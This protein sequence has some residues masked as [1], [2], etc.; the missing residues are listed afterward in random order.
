MEKT[1]LTRKQLYDLMW[2]EPRTAIAKRFHITDAELKK[3]CESMNIPL[4]PNGYWQK[5]QFK[6]PVDIKKLPVDY[7]GSD[8]VVFG[9]TARNYQLNDSP[10]GIQNRLVRELE[11]DPDLPLMVPDRLTKPDILITSTQNYLD[12]VRRYDWSK[13]D[14][15]PSRSNTL[16]IEVSKELLPRA[17]RIMNAIISLLKARKHSMIVK[18]DRTLA[19]IYGE[20]ILIRLRERYKRVASKEKYRDWENEPTRKLVLI[21]GDNWRSIEVNDGIEGLEMKLAVILAKLEIWA[22]KEIADRIERERRHKIYEEERRLES[23]LKARKEKELT[24]FKKIFWAATRYNQAN[25]L[26]DYI[27]NVETT[28]KESGSLTE[29]KQE[30]IDW[31][32]DKIDWYDPLIG[33]EDQLLDGFNKNSLMIEFLSQQGERSQHSSGQ[34]GHYSTW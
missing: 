10:S 25:F 26:R 9:G 11:N 12:A 13:G 2:K 22:K 28:A 34:Y 16:K 19:V 7:T 15:S 23:E 33:K 18:E 32:R 3:I 4:P 6:K 24:E 27:R 30:W 5:L 31:A 1:K 21:M 8:E 14:T 17:L 20:E 29:E